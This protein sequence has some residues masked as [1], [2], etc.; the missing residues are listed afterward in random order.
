MKNVRSILVLML[1]VFLVATMAGTA[2]A[3]VPGVAIN[4]PPPPPAPNVAVKGG[5]ALVTLVVTHRDT[6]I[7][8]SHYVDRLYLF[9]GD[10]LVK[11]WTYN[12][13]TANKNEVWTESVV[14]PAIKDM[15]LRAIAH[16][17]LHGYSAA[18]VLLRVLPEGTTP[19][20][21]VQTDSKVA[22]TQVNGYTDAST[23]TGITAHDQ[24]LIRQVEQN[25]MTDI[26]HE[27][28]ETTDFLNSP[29]GQQFLTGF[30]YTNNPGAT[31]TTAPPPSG[32]P[33]IV[34]TDSMGNV[35]NGP[36]A[37]SMGNIKAAQ[38]IESIVDDSAG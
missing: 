35:I 2:L 29:E 25:D 30:D 4:A 17:T 21:M 1:S 34:W 9:N 16:C 28:A 5:Q 19:S 38:G 8:S 10:N 3:N 36:Q 24:Q 26:Q 13:K 32:A 7:P 22:G 33:Q 14:V 23:A 37:I 31:I 20:Q 15:N 18:N 12:D 27:R 11:E 6:S